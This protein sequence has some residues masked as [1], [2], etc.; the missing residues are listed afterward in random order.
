[1]KLLD[2]VFLFFAMNEIVSLLSCF[3]QFWGQLL[4]VLMN[5]VLDNQ[6][7]ILECLLSV[8]TKVKKYE[9]KRDM[10]CSLA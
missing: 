1:M 4:N 2:S 10:H 6:T 5:V 9:K 8:Q 7:I 3:R